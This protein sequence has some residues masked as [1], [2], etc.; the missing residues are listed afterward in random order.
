MPRHASAGRAA[1][2]LAALLAVGL[3]ACGDDEPSQPTEPAVTEPFESGP[4]SGSSGPGDSGAADGPS[5]AE[6]AEALVGLS[7]ADAEAAATQQGWVLRVVRRDGED[8]AATA[9]FRPD[10]VNV[11]VTDGEV[12]AVVSIG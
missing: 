3:V 2:A 6:A 1:F 8:L 5:A 9:D 11:E 12:M 4:E 10:R 7:E